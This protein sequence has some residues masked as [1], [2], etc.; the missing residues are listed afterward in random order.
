MHGASEQANMI[1]ENYEVTLNHEANSHI[2][3][4]LDLK[5]GPYYFGVKSIFKSRDIDGIPETTY[6]LKI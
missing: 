1:A 2:V 3:A 5:P 6:I 4:T